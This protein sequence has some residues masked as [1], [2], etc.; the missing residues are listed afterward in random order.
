MKWLFLVFVFLFPISAS[1]Q[2]KERIPFKS[3]D[4]LK[5]VNKYYKDV[6]IIEEGF[7]TYDVTGNACYMLTTTR[8]ELFYL[9]DNNVLKFNS[10]DTTVE[11][12]QV[13]NDIAMFAIQMNQHCKTLIYSVNGEAKSKLK[14]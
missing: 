6:P 5:L 13:G 3:Y 11:V 2:S 14:G 7:K 1:C 12:Y 10:A 9:Y 8:G 4:F